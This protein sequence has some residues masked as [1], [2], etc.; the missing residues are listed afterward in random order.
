MENKQFF[1]YVFVFF[2]DG[3]DVEIH[4]DDVIGE[5]PKG[6]REYGNYISYM[7]LSSV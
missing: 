7:I 4:N 3:H 6:K 2:L 5:M 1:S